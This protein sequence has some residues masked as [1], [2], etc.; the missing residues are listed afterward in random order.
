[1][2]FVTLLAAGGLASALIAS[3]T[4]HASPHAEACLEKTWGYLKA[5]GYEF[6]AINTCAYPV[7]VWFKSRK[8]PLVQGV[9]HPGE[10][11]RTGLTIDKF[12]TERKETGWVGAVCSVSE[13]PDKAIS[14]ATW[15]AIVDGKYECKKP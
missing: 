11:F 10:H 4:A 2:R 8:G 6:G 13:V 5:V 9:V 14:D 15:D 3:G 1:M 12:E 7:A